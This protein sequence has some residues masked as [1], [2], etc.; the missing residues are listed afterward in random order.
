MVPIDDPL[1]KPLGPNEKGELLVKGPQV[2]SRYHKRPKETENAFADG[3]LRTGDLVYYDENEMFYVVDRLKELIKVKGFQ[4]APTE[5]E[6]IL[7]SYPDISDAAVIGVPHKTYGEV[8]RAY[9][10]EKGKAKLNTEK[11]NEFM[12]QKVSE[13]K[14]L[15]GGVVVVRSLPKTASGKILRKDLKLHY[16]NESK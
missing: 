16:Q 14:Q 1:G 13:F 12:S 4:V 15:E 6:E 2:M 11:L 3:W 9:V 7:R 8:P 10:V 5:L